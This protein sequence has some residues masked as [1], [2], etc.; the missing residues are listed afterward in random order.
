[1]QSEDSVSIDFD[2]I[3]TALNRYPT[4]VTS[5][6]LFGF[7]FAKAMQGEQDMGEALIDLNPYFPLNEDQKSQ[8][9]PILCAM[10]MVTFKNISAEFVNLADLIPNDNHP[11]SMRLYC[12]ADLVKGL[13]TGLE[14]D[15]TN[16]Y[17]EESE[18]L[19]EI[20]TDFKA[21]TE[22]NVDEDESEQNEENYMQLVEYVRVGITF[23]AEH[24]FALKTFA[25]HK[26]EMVEH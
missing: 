10:F 1:M 16:K 22:I 9:M 5:C 21:M 20:L 25:N 12:L 11:L 13:L 23:L 4:K 17:F 6:F 19:Q 2:Q 8:F 24:A 18:G 7:I 15:A 14:L 26:N 3:E